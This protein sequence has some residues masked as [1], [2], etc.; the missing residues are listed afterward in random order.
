MAEVDERQV[1]DEGGVGG[2]AGLVRRAV[3]QLMGNVDAPAVARVHVE[4]GG[5][6]TFDEAGGRPCD[7][8]RGLPAERPGEGLVED[9]ALGVV[10]G[11]DEASAV[12]DAYGVGEEGAVGASP[13]LFQHLVVDVVGGSALGLLVLGVVLQA[14][15]LRRQRFHILFVALLPVGIFV[16]L[17]VSLFAARRHGSC[18]WQEQQRR[19]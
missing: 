11:G 19:E 13:A 4:Q 9:I 14:L 5:R 10:G 3:T 2:D 17:F 1:E 16:G 6:E 15:I 8:G 12:A 7:G 18:Q